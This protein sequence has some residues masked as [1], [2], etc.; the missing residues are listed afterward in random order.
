MPSATST[1]PTTQL[2]MTFG[3]VNAMTFMGVPSR[4]TFRTPER[5][6]PAPAVIA[7]R[8][9]AEPPKTAAKTSMK[10][11][12]I[13]R[14]ARNPLVVIPKTTGPSVLKTSG[15]QVS[16]ARPNTNRNPQPPRADA[17]Q[18]AH[19]GSSPF[20]PRAGPDPGR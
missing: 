10:P 18:A 15:R 4:N 9:A 2:K 16:P 19:C 6:N 13:D 12:A 11:T 14:N 17:V 1:A 7:T 3:I 8:P 5:M 20:A